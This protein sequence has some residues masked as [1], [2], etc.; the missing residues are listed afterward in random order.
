MTK[1]L[2]K[3]PHQES[4]V[5]DTGESLRRG[6]DM[7]WLW[8]LRGSDGE[9]IDVSVYRDELAEEYGYKILESGEF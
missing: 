5:S 3:V 1:I 7:V 6:K 9:L 8:V 4:Y 2:K